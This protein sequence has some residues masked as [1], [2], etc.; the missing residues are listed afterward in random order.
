MLRW[1]VLAML[2]GG[3][4]GGHWESGPIVCQSIAGVPICLPDARWVTDQ[5]TPHPPVPRSVPGGGPGDGDA[6]LKY[7]GLG[8]VVI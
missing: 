8:G 4:A 7:P 2:L 5:I 1:F 3:C 6:G